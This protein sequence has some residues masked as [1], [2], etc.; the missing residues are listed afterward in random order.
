MG[1]RDR[2]LLEQLNQTINALTI[3]AIH[4]CLSAWNPDKFRVPPDIG[5]GSGRQHK[6][7]TQTITSPV[8]NAGRYLGCCLESD[9]CSSSLAVIG[10]T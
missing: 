5:W 3:T 4:H 1:M 7:D 9:F 8:N 10:N 6:C 2:S